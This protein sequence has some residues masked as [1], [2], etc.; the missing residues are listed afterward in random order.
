MGGFSVFLLSPYENEERE[1]IRVLVFMGRAHAVRE[2]ATKT[3]RCGA[4]CRAVSEYS[5]IYAQYTKEKL[6]L[7]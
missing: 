1:Q 5:R 3:A 6:L 7:D 2:A 4:G